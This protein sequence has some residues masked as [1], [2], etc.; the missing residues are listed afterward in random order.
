MQPSERLKYHLTSENLWLYILSLAGKKPVYAYALRKEIKK[1]FGFEPSLVM[2]YLVLPRLELSGFIRSE[3]KGRRKYYAITK[4]GKE[5]LEKGKK[6][7]KH[8]A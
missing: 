5:E 8:I 4:R 3:I 2:L 7:M 6:Q 1:R